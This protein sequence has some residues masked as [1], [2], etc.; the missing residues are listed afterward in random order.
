[1]KQRNISRLEGIITLPIILF[2][3]LITA[4]MTFSL[5]DHHKL[6]K[7]RDR[8]LEFMLINTALEYKRHGNITHWLDGIKAITSKDS[9]FVGADWLDYQRVL[10]LENPLDRE[11]Y[12][13]YEI[14][15]YESN[16][17]HST[18]KEV[19]EDEDEA[20]GYL[21]IYKK[22]NQFVK[23]ATLI[24]FFYLLCLGILL[25]IW[26]TWKLIIKKFFI[27]PLEQIEN[28]CADLAS[29]ITNPRIACI[30]ENS[31]FADLHKEISNFQNLTKS[32]KTNF[33][34]E[35]NNADE[36]YLELQQKAQE[37]RNALKVY[38][39]K[40]DTEIEFISNQQNSVLT[41]KLSSLISELRKAST[42]ASSDDNNLEK[43]IKVNELIDLIRK[44]VESAPNRK[45]KP[46][47]VRT[48]IKS[49]SG[50]V[51]T[52]TQRLKLY[53]RLLIECF[54]ESVNDDPFLHI[55]LNK[56]R[57]HTLNLSILMSPSTSDYSEYAVNDLLH[58]KSGRLADFTK[59]LS[60]D[61]SIPDDSPNISVTL[62]LKYATDSTSNNSQDDE[63]GTITVGYMGQRDRLDDLQTAAN[64]N[65][66]VRFV[67]I[68]N[69]IADF[70]LEALIM[71]NTIDSENKKHTIQLF[72][73]ESLVIPELILVT[74]SFSGLDNKLFDHIVSDKDELLE[75]LTKVI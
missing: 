47:N 28:Q 5:Y 19:M 17:S 73:Q 43:P 54:Q 34:N 24:G 50:F 29:E 61:L 14:P 66:K 69:P 59:A 4:T 44:D 12:Y 41:K 51:I 20:V 25:S 68:T 70:N 22:E 32:I 62:P 37:K 64:L 31:I 46:L 49:I 6:L 63:P 57:A 40:I 10:Q 39:D 74:E 71:D 75:V 35:L 26:K 27:G 42:E 9:N 21:A 23:H 53:L 60:A 55:L 67:Y 33:E 48:N 11:D 36:N 2:A 18:G 56:N 8:G 15:V 13:V 3:I 38:L 72:K 65:D 7:E 30:D 1:M 52:D 45:G 16:I 58:E